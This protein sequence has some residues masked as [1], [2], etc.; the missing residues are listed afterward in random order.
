MSSDALLSEAL[1]KQINDNIIASD[2]QSDS[3]SLMI[4]SYRGNLTLSVAK[5]IGS[6]RPC[7]FVSV[8]YADCPN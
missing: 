8:L 1:M 3:K 4:G 5:L 6:D 7:N 2:R